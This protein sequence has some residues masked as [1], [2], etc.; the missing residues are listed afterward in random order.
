MVKWISGLLLFFS[1]TQA[2]A[3]QPTRVAIA[4]HPDTLSFSLRTTDTHPGDTTYLHPSSPAT[5]TRYFNKNLRGV[6]RGDTTPVLGTVLISFFADSNGNYTG[7][8]YEETSAPPDLVWEIIRATN[9]LSQ[10]P[11]IPTTV[12]GRP[13]A[14]AV[15]AKLI[16]KRESDKTETDPT[17]DIVVWIYETIIDHKIS[18]Q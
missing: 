5:L 18:I 13:F 15:H 10:V 6:Y 17:T 2:S 8:C 7:S 3:Q 4:T 12:A 16:F 11:M 9:R 1:A 14:S